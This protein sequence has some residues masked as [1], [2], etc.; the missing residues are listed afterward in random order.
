MTEIETN[1]VYE[2]TS[3]TTYLFLTTL[4]AYY[5]YTFK[6][7]AVT[8][9]QGPFSYNFTIQMPEDGEPTIFMPLLN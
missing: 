4:H 2:Y 7:A 3:N 9:S 1:A 8:I 5:S 6:M